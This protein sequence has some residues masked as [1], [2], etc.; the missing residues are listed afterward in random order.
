MNETFRTTLWRQFGAAIDMLES[1]IRECPE[2]LWCDRREQ[3]EYWYLTFHTLFW[4][5]LYLSG[6]VE[7]FVPPDPF[8]LAEL[9]PAGVIP[10]V[11]YTQAELLTYLEHSRRKCR[12]VLDGLTDEAASR[13]LQFG[14]GHTTYLE[15]MLYN[16]RHVQHHVAQLNL[17]G[18]RQS[19][20]I[21]RQPGWT[22][23]WCGSATN[24]PERIFRAPGCHLEP[25]MATRD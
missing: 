13:P 19:A 5:D 23:R 16:M 11:P 21:S 18:D 22:N 25:A 8:D 24:G 3:P 15:L 1:A 17:M 10:E 4:L 6:P 20:K 2:Q 9:D 7:G 14:W 12:S